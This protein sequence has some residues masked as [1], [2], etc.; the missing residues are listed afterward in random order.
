MKPISDVSALRPEAREIATKFLHLASTWQPRGDVRVDGGLPVKIWETYRP[1]SVQAELVAKGVSRAGPGQSPH[2]HRLAFD[3]VL[4]VDHPAWASLKEHPAGAAQPW[5]L[6]LDVAG[7]D[8]VR[9][10]PRPLV[11]SVWLAI[12]RIAKAAAGLDSN[13][14]APQ[15]WGGDWYAR[16]VDPKKAL[17]GWDAGHIQH[18]EWRALAGLHSA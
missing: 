5:D 18:P 2:Q 16:G 3:V 10:V 6:G 1:S 14:E 11:F 8:G 7:A 15:V 4:D 12:G 13:K 9:A 17:I